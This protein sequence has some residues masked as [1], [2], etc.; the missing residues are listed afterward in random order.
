V[1]VGLLGTWALG[2]LDSL[3]GLYFEIGPMDSWALGTWAHGL[4]SWTLGLLGNWALGHLGSW[5][6]GHLGNWIIGPL[7]S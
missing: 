7:G 3:V 5:A 6:I 4:G 2:Q 1:A